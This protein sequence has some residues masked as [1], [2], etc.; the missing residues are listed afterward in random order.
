MPLTPVL[1]AISGDYMSRKLRYLWQAFEKLDLKDVHAPTT[2][3]CK[4]WMVWAS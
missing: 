2:S 1:Y 3:G 4:I